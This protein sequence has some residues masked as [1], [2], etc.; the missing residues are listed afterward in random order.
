MREDRVFLSIEGPHTD[1]I[2]VRLVAVDGSPVTPPLPPPLTPSLL[3]LLSFPSLTPSSPSLPP[4]RR[5]TEPS[6][7]TRFR[8]AAVGVLGDH[9]S[10]HGEARDTVVQDLVREVFDVGFLFENILV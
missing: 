4:V 9:S 6:E 3:S 8:I 1:S 2:C 10:G 7:A 5:S